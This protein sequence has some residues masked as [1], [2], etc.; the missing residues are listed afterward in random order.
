LRRAISTQQREGKNRRRTLHVVVYVLEVADDHDRRV[1]AYGGVGREH[2]RE[3]LDVGAQ[4]ASD[5]SKIWPERR[6][7]ATGGGVESVDARQDR[8]RV[9]PGAPG[10]IRGHSPLG[11]ADAVSIFAIHALA[12]R[13]EPSAVASAAPVHRAQRWLAVMKNERPKDASPRSF[14]DWFR[15]FLR[16]KSADRKRGGDGL[17]T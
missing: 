4:I 8:I 6:R 1:A 9:E 10:D 15:F 2:G 5:C 14:V 3:T 7:L 11:V 17:C 13:Y 16:D 12:S